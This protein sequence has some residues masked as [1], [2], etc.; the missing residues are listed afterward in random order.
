MNAFSKN[1]T[2][3]QNFYVTA[4]SSHIICFGG[5]PNISPTSK[6]YLLQYT[7][8]K[9]KRSNYRPGQALRVPGGCGSQI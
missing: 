8:K 5:Y 1:Y 6:Y 2:D 9:V 3:I 4:Y 7:G